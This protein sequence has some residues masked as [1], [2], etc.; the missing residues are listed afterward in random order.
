MSGFRTLTGHF[1]ICESLSAHLRVNMHTTL[2]MRSIKNRGAK[3]TRI[4][5]SNENSMYYGYLSIVAYSPQPCAP[6]KL[7]LSYET[8]RTYIEV[9]ELDSGPLFR[10]RLNAK[11]QKLGSNG[12]S[13]SSM[14]RLLES[15]LDQLPGALH[16]EKIN[17]E[18][19]RVRVYSTHTLRKTAATLALKQ[20][21]DIRKVQ[22]FLVHEHVNTT[23]GYDMREFSPQEGVSH[24]LPM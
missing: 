4:S 3:L 13:V 21:V 7:M 11:S 20:G 10:T 24:L 5:K 1:L 2:S 22:E 17:G 18:E 14:S 8:I 9:A 15:Y 6:Q 19:K 16:Y 12:F 23:E